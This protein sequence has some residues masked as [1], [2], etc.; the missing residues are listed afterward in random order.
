MS[1][2]IYFPRSF[3]VDRSI[4]LDLPTEVR[5][6]MLECPHLHLWL[7]LAQWGRMSCCISC[8]VQKWECTPAFT[9]LHALHWSQY[10]TVSQQGM[11]SLTKTIQ[12]QNYT[13]LGPGFHGNVLKCNKQHSQ[14][15]ICCIILFTFILPCLLFWYCLFKKHLNGRHSHWSPYRQC[16]LFLNY[17]AG[18]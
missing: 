1:Q 14:S 18:S 4:I 11:P 3:S 5:S 13:E 7:T 10:E 2:C 12:M 15:E 9:E 17:H 6:S 8:D 16:F